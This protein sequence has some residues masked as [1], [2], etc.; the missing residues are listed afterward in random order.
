MPRVCLN[1]HNPSQVH[2]EAQ[3]SGDPRFCQADSALIAITKSV[4]LNAA[5]ACLHTTQLSPAHPED[6]TLLG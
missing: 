6:T 3:L 4:Y 2:S 1:L 5:A